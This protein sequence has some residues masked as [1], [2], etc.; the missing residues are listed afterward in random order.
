[1]RVGPEIAQQDIDYCMERAKAT[2]TEG[3]TDPGQNAA[4]GAATSSVVGQPR[5]VRVVRFSDRRGKAQ[6]RALLA[7]SSVASRRR[8]SRDCF[9][10]NRPRHPL[11]NSWIV[12][13]VKRATSLRDGNSLSTGDLPR[14]V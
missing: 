3:G 2:S 10:L 11:G 13:F 8:L 4:A 12:A 1:M 9:G 14:A 7:G 6:Q 5:V